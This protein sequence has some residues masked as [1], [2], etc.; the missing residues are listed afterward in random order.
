MEVNR[1]LPVTW[2]RIGQPVPSSRSVNKLL[3]EGSSGVV[4]REVLVTTGRDGD[5]NRIQTNYQLSGS[6]GFRW[7]YRSGGIR[8]FIKRI[9]YAYNYGLSQ[10]NTLKSDLI[11]NFVRGKLT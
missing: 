1:I 11:L 7:D 9:F 2:T 3:C 4:L 5:T 6:F 10:I 8:H